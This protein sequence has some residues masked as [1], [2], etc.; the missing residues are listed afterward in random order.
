MKEFRLFVY[1]SLKSGELHHES[2]CQD[3]DCLGT[4]W[5]PGRIYRRPDGYPSLIIAGEQ[6]LTVGTGDI[7]QDGA[8]ASELESPPAPLTPLNEPWQKIAGELL[9]LRD[10]KSRIKKID[11]FEDFYPGQKS[12]YLRVLTQVHLDDGNTQVAWTYISAHP[13]KYMRAV[14]LFNEGDYFNAHDLW[15]EIWGESTGLEKQFYQTLIQVAVAL[16]KWQSGIPGGAIKMYHAAHKNFLTLPDNYQGLD[17]SK[18][19][20]DFTGL[21]SGLI[22]QTKSAAPS[23]P[24][25]RK[26]QLTVT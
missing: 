25:E 17:I 5:I 16:L 15:E 4:A 14:C 23:F 22:N 3:A 7:S 2:Y 19:E 8:R 9:S 10:P 20:S 24:T 18:L 12:D 26:L 11:E 13:E 1:G 21:L 6:V